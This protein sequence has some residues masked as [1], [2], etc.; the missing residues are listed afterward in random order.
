[1]NILGTNIRATPNFTQYPAFLMAVLTKGGADDLA[2]Y[3]GIISLPGFDGPATF[4]S[5]H[6]EYLQTLA[7]AAQK[8]AA[9]GRKLR[10]EEARS[11]F[12]SIEE[13]EYRA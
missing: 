1:M 12:P 7:R 11:H 3:E 2:V 8:I 9:S 6:P 5:R 4:D 13:K 10:F